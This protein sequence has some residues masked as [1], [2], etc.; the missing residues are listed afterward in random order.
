VL[1]TLP[2]NESSSG[3]YEDAAGD[4]AVWYD[5]GHINGVTVEITDS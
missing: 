1:C 3:P 4:T 5:S 2:V